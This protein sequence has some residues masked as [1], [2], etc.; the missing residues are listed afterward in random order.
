MSGEVIKPDVLPPTAL[1]VVTRAEI[2]V[3][4]ATAHRFPRNM[5]AFLSKAKTMVEADLDTAMSCIYKRPVGRDEDTGQQKIAEGESIRL[6]EIV[7]ANYGNLR[8][9]GR[10]IEVQ[11]RY[12]V[13]EGFAHDLESNYAAKAEHREST[14]TKSGKPYSE[15]QAAVAAKAAI[16]KAMRDAIFRVCP[17]SLCKPLMAAARAVIS[18]QQTPLATRREK[19]MQWTRSLGV[20]EPRVFALLDIKGIAD[21]TEEHLITLTGIRTAL[22]EGDETIE[23][24]F[25]E[26]EK[27]KT[28]PTPEQAGN[29][30]SVLAKKVT[31]QTAT[32]PASTTEA[33]A[34]TQSDKPK[35]AAE[36]KALMDIIDG[37][38]PKSEPE[39][40]TPP[41][42]T[43]TDKLRAIYGSRRI[44]FKKALNARGLTFDTWETAPIDVQESMLKEL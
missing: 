3:Q 25:P 37:K 31:T 39:K 42:E 13:A 1:D 5:T 7:A 27:K 36:D 34:E 40:Q 30:A 23:S 4:I 22:Q 10:V 16:S 35:T 33:P 9:Y 29:G 8:V 15:R 12:V 21:I 18:G 14:V 26:I 41:A 43:V 17:K 2:D 28:E 20:D 11:P 6:A 44:P 38:K 19:A 24:A 32:Q